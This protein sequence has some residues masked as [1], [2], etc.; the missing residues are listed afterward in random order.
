[1]RLHEKASE[2]KLVEKVKKRIK[3][4]AEGKKKKVAEREGRRVDGEVK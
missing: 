3:K 1:M 2:D 4:I